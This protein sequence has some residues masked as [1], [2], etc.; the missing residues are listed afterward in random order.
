MNASSN[1]W[2]YV[3]RDSSGNVS[4]IVEKVEI[5][6]EA[7]VGVYGWNRAVDA[8][9]SFLD[10]FHRDLRTNNEF[11]V[12]PTYNYLIEN[13]FSVETMLIGDHGVAVHGLGT[14]KDLDDFLCHEQSIQAA[15]NFKTKLGLLPKK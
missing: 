11:Y 2:S 6:N 10:T 14:P 7:T 12:A 4:N 15:V 8:K 9:V 13:G 1:A 3:G 5:S